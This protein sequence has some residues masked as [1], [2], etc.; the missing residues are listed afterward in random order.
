M[1]RWHVIPWLHLLWVGDPSTKVLI[2]QRDCTCGDGSSAS[3]VGEVWTIAP[4]R[5]GP[6]DGVT[7]SAGSHQDFAAPQPL[8]VACRVSGSFQLRGIPLDECV[9]GLSKNKESHV[10]VLKPAELGTLAAVD[11]GTIRSQPGYRSLSRHEVCLAVEVRHPK[12]MNYV[13]R[14]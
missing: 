4:A 10:C 5:R 2:M 8:R 9:L 6:S 3:D 14:R 13:G 1:N 12:A 11:S 7:R